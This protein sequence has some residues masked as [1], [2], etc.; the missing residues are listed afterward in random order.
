V[1]EP[2]LWTKRLLLRRWKDADREPFARISADPEVMQYRLAPLSPRESDDLIDEAEASF[3]RDG[4]G[5]WA[6]ERIEDGGLLGF[7]GLGTSAFDAPFCPAVDVGWTLAR[8]AWGQGYATEGAIAALGY[9]FDL[10]RLD[11]VVAHTSEQNERS[12]A[13]MQRLGMTHE[14]EDD[15]DAPWYQ[16]G[17]PRR[18]FVL[19]RIKATEWRRRREIGR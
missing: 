11:E 3:D 12:Q 10:L 14:P 9:A 13:V 4:F 7:I 16:P 8:E 17:H 2:A 6:V 1:R 19:Y 5:L 15:F 18:R